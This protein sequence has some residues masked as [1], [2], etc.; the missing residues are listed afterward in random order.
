[1]QKLSEFDKT[2]YA[3]LEK[4]N[5][6][7]LER[8]NI[9]VVKDNMIRNAKNRRAANL[10]PKAKTSVQHIEQTSQFNIRDGASVQSVIKTEHRVS[11]HILPETDDS[12]VAM[13]GHPVIMISTGNLDSSIHN[14]GSQGIMIAQNSTTKKSPLTKTMV[15][16]T[17]VTSNKVMNIEE[18]D[19]GKL[20]DKM[21][22]EIKIADSDEKNPDTLKHI[23]SGVLQA[24]GVFT[25]FEFC[26]KKLSNSNKDT[27]RVLSQ[28]AGYDPLK[29]SY[30]SDLSANKVFPTHNYLFLQFP[31][32]GTLVIKDMR[33]IL[34]LCVF[35]SVIIIFLFWYT[36]RLIVKQKKISEV[37]NDFINNMTHELKTPIATIS[38]A[39]DAISNPLIKN[40]VAKF[41]QYTSILKEENQKLNSHVEHVLQMA[42]LEKGEFEPDMKK[43]DVIEVIQEAIRSHA[44]K[45]D[46]KKAIVS[47][48][49]EQK[50]LTILA[51]RANMLIVMNNLLDNALKY[52]GEHCIIDI[53]T[54]TLS[55]YA[56]ISIKD[57]GIGIESDLHKKIFEK[58][59]RVQ[60]GDVHDTKGFGLGLSFVRS[61][62]EKHHGTIELYSELNKGSEFIIK[63]PVYES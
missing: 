6:K 53:H 37:K 48:H 9:K 25:P 3:S 18:D 23:I 8:Q 49:P 63:I 14:P 55:G 57:N 44:L 41:D 26:L 62:L 56:V 2:I 59:Y 28:S 1:M 34:L 20:M 16:K 22:I 43:T 19:I 60:S 35:F 47:F 32:A 10:P 4:I 17:T 50:E 39:V 36:V 5:D 21:L 58:F 61:M 33:N 54:K 24:K 15:T 27:A 46:E 13:M 52:S 30:R 45:I 51:D 12:A 40:D 29:T 31:E 7:L 42:L 11:K 38:L